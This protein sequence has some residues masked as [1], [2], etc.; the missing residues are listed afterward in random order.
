LTTNIEE[1]YNA[2]PYPERKPSDENK[3]LIMGS[4]SSPKE[5]DHHIFGGQRGWS[6]PLRALFA[7]GGTG[8]GLIQL[9]QM[10]TDAGRAYDITYIDL[11]KSARKIA[12]KRAKIRGLKNITFL[13]CSLV[14][15]PKYGPF[16]YIDCCGVLHHMPDPQVGFDALADALAPN[17]GLGFMV[18]A[19]YGRSGV[20]PLQEAF[21]QLSEG[22]SPKERLDFGQEVFKRVPHNHL[23]KRNDLIG[24]H[25]VSE[26]GFY[27]LLL[28]S[29]DISCTVSDVFCYL[30]KA[31]LELANFTQPALYSLDGLLPPE[32]KR[33]KNTTR[34]DEMQ[35][36]EKLR[37]NMKTHVGY[38]HKAGAGM[39]ADPIA[40]TSIPHFIGEDPKKAAAFISERGGLP[41]AING[42]KIGL[43]IP[44]AAAKLIA[45]IDGATPISELQKKSGLSLDAF[46]DAWSK[47]SDL[48]AGYGLLL[49]SSLNKNNK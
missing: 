33:P 32:Y 43:G 8:D 35:L 29:Q 18:Y 45:A 10:L 20:Y 31:G 37:G 46:N 2:Y 40:P 38:A 7:G 11:S 14:D 5:I 27:D 49:Y 39:K 1:H 21:G 36:S 15:A 42:Q 41:V 22:M 48:L 19:P 16:D 3:R 24:D 6:K 28:H 26:A 17:G 23:F 34:M 25:K 44:P 9:A 4:P 13:T 47:I 30:E 12:E